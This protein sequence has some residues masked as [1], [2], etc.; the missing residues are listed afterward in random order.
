V[1]LDFENDR[2]EVLFPSLGPVAW[3]GYLFISFEERYLA[4]LNLQVVVTDFRLGSC[5]KYREKLTLA[6]KEIDGHN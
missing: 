6:V 3:C 5:I 2:F 4:S 1:D